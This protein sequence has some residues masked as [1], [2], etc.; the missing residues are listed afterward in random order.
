MTTMDQS[1]AQFAL[2]RV[3]SVRTGTDRGNYASELKDLPARLHTGG[4]A[5]TMATYMRSGDAAPK[6]QRRAIY[7]W[8]EAWMRM[9]PV[10]YP[11]D[12]RLIDAITG[13]N[14]SPTFD[15][16]GKYREASSE[17]RAIANWMK[18]FAE[19]FLE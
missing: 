16:E 6:P 13:N 15:V 9:E 4:L 17:A 19:A 10:Q 14:A 5:Q 12:L 11:A 7:D 8:L 18:K 3:E 2:A 1:R